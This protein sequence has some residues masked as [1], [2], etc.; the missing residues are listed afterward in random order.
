MQEPLQTQQ[1]RHLFHVLKEMNSLLVYFSFCFKIFFVCVHVPVVSMTQCVHMPWYPYAGQRT[2]FSTGPPFH[3]ET[4]YRVLFGVCVCCAAV[5]ARLACPQ[6]SENSP[7][8]TTHYKHGITDIIHRF[9]RF[10][11]YKKYCIQSPI[12]SA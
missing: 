11:L 2:A 1:F 7:V 8:S 3:L 5:H 9:W 12:F 6:I 10:D 4:S